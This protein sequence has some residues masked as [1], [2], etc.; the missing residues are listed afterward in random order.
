MGR[1]AKK[2]DPLKADG[3]QRR[4]WLFW[5]AGA[6]VLL[7]ALGLTVGP[8]LVGAEGGAG[9]AAEATQVTISMSGWEPNRIEARV[10]E[11]VTL[12]LVNLDNQFHT[13]GGGWHNFVLER[14]GMAEEVGPKKTLTFTFTPT[15]KGEFN[16][17]CDICCGGK[18]NPYMN[19]TLV[20]S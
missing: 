7:L 2:K 15:E 20:V 18:E 9:G 10:G 14:F 1:H 12:R 11:P 4:V 19:G 17:Y 16:F 3:Q 6:L 5:S 13:D 8:L